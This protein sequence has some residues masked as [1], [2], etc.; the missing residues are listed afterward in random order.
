MLHVATC[1][2][3][4]IKQGRPC[5]PL[6]RTYKYRMITN[7]WSTPRTGSVWYTLYLSLQ[8][9][10]SIV[11]NELFNKHHMQMYYSNV[12][13]KI[14]NHNEYMTGYF[15]REYCLIDDKFSI[16]YKFERRHRNIKEEESYRFEILK[17][18]MSSNNFLLHNHVA[19]LNE[20]IRMFLMQAAEK[21]IYIHRRN[22]RQ[23]LAS[24]AIAYS[25]KLFG[26]TETSKITHEPVD[27][28][29]PIHLIHL[30]E[31][32][33]IW[34][35]LPKTDIITYEDIPFRDIDKFPKKQNIDHYARL[36]DKMIKI[37]DDIV[38]NYEKICPRTLIGSAA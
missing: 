9:P 5:T 23:Q 15:Y 38:I 30:I 12:D 21:N 32:I 35:N 24:Y 16:Q 7:L 17:N 34:D 6:L 11:V 3:E 18:S 29:D 28:I 2:Q 19:P 14:I 25:T 36:S 33:K 1:E 26:V 27:D 10:T 37:I 20:D 8:D 31:R 22:K 13:G 4:Y